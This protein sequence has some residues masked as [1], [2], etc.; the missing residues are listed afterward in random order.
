MFHSTNIVMNLVTY[1]PLQ[2]YETIALTNL[3][4]VDSS[5]TTLWTGLFP[6][7]GCLL[8]FY[9]YC[10]I[11]ILVVYANSVDPDQ[12][13]HSAASELL[14]NYLFGVSRLK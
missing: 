1:I 6:K 13:P 12:M 3:C 7:A 8:N 10:F 4:Q 9:Y 2:L 11:E 5:T 14:A